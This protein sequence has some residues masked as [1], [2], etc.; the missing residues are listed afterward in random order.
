MA[1]N[2]SD[3]YI[4]RQF[5]V[6]GLG[7]RFGDIFVDELNKSNRD[8]RAILYDLLPA[9]YATRPLSRVRA[10]MLES[11]ADD[12]AESRGEVIARYRINFEAELA[13]LIN[14]QYKKSNEVYSR[15][16]LDGEPDEEPSAFLIG[17]LLAAGLY[18]GR[19]IDQWFDD[20]KDADRARINQS[21]SASVNNGA[22]EKQVAQT[23]LGTKAQ[24][25]KD[26]DLNTS[27]N[28]ART[29]ARTI[30]TGVSIAALGQWS[31][32]AKKNGANILEL[33]SAILDSRTTFICASLNG[34]VYSV[35]VGPYPP[36][37]PNCRSTRYPIPYAMANPSTLKVAGVDFAKNARRRVGGKAWDEMSP[38]AHRAQ[39]LDEKKNW[40]RKNVGALPEDMDFERGL[41]VNQ[42][43]FSWIISALLVTTHGR[44]EA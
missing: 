39:V 5:Y 37:H 34:N 20:F 8:S 9:I 1:T 10:N 7:N 2:L 28:S 12:I 6:I 29:L 35:G 33:Y 17:S 44:V 36:L 42:K 15:I 30:T 38:R 4:R 13:R 26:G 43:G 11:L 18:D 21:I 32:S 40:L 3:E 23:L 27:Q 14:A 22:T 31:K 16:P 25:F 24:G 19:T 41:I